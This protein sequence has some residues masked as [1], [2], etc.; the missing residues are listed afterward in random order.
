MENRADSPDPL[1]PP[2]QHAG[3]QQSA[4]ATVTHA[5]VLRPDDPADWRFLHE[6]LADAHPDKDAVSAL[7]DVFTS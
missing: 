2:A 3:D 1:R 6:L 5:L 7:A 4:V